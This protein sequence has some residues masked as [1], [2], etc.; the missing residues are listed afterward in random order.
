MDVKRAAGVKAAAG[1]AL[2]AGLYFRR[3]VLAVNRFGQD[4]GTGGLTHPTWSAEKKSLRQVLAADGIFKGIGDMV[5]PNY[6][7]ER[8]G[9]VFTR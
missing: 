7:I 1:F 4:T 8:G 3:D 2:V 5:L 6:A 9:A